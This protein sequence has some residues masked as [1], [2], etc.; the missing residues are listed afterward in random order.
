MVTGGSETLRDKEPTTFTQLSRYIPLLVS[1][2][3]SRPYIGLAGRASAYT[4]RNLPT[5]L[6]YYLNVGGTGANDRMAGDI[7]QWDV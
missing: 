6:S 3:S 4:E 2:P 1:T 7:H 5:Y